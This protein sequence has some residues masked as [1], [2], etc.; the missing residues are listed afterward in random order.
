LTQIVTFIHPPV[1]VGRVVPLEGNEEAK[2]LDIIF[3]K[4]LRTTLEDAR[5][6]GNISSTRT[7][8]LAQGGKG[9]VVYVPIFS[10]EEFEGFIA[11]VFRI[12]IL[13]GSILDEKLVK[14]FSVALFDGEEKI[15]ESQKVRK[16]ENELAYESRINIHGISWQMRV[17]PTEAWMAKGDSLLPKAVL[18]VGFLITFFL[19]LVTFLAQKTTYYAK[20]LENERKNLIHAKEKVEKASQA[21]S[22]FLGSMSHELRTP[23]NAIIGFSDL[24]SKHPENLSPEDLKESADH[25]QNAG[26]GLL[27]LINQV[28]NFQKIDAG[29]FQPDIV[30]L[31]VAPLIRN[32][33]NLLKPLANMHDV[34]LVDEI[35]EEVFVLGDIDSLKQVLFNLISNAIKYNREG[36]SV[37]VK[38]DK[39]T[40]ENIRINVAD[41][42]P[43]IK[44]ENQAFLFEPF[45]RLG[46]EALTTPGTGI[47]LT[48]AKQLT[49]HMGGT[50]GFISNPDQ[51][52]CFYIELPISSSQK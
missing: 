27:E 37:T 21:K 43:G 33:M 44:E 1:N 50:L 24:L 3:E 34:R 20:E 46:V 26:H 18:S 40:D 38:C 9:F 31:E 45:N 6:K 7:I 16:F 2:G 15:Y 8:N 25:I 41:T 35:E 51:G 14:G 32:S 11:G 48:I 49:E 52:S 12:Q 39:I 4:R 13:L 29:K 36:G 19:S 10:S 28:L 23:L 17:W 30:P 47:G 42:G 5:I 22:N